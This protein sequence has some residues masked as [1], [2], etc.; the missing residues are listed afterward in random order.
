[1]K[2][3]L[4]HVLAGHVGERELPTE[5]LQPFGDERP[6]MTGR[7]RERGRQDRSTSGPIETV[8]GAAFGPFG[9]TVRSVLEA[10][11]VAFS[12]A[13]GPGVS[14][15][16]DEAADGLDGATTIEI[17]DTDDERDNEAEDA[18]GGS[19]P[20]SETGSGSDAGNASE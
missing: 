7:S 17:E 5:T 10:N 8:F 13:F 20:G 16:D 11:R 18:N 12:V 9:A 1:M 3:F 14:R 6:T 2:W 15:T 19:D 4:A